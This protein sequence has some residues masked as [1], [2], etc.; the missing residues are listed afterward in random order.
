MAACRYSRFK[1]NLRIA[2]SFAVF[3]ACASAGVS[4]AASSAPP[5]ISALRKKSARVPPASSSNASASAPDL[6]TDSSVKSDIFWLLREAG[7]LHRGSRLGL[8][9]RRIGRSW[10]RIAACQIAHPAHVASL[11]RHDPH[12]RHHARPREVRDLT[13]EGCYRHLLELDRGCQELVR[14]ARRVFEVELR[15]LRCTGPE[16]LPERL[17]VIALLPTYA[18]RE[19]L[20]LASQGAPAFDR[21]IEGGLQVLDL[22]QPLQDPP[23]LLARRLRRRRPR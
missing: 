1:S 10:R 22:Q 12:R 4:S 16:Q 9:C 13:V 15:L 5:P 3:R 2:T 23:V 19:L 7:G 17:H 20:L 8:G 18:H 14:I 21:R 11:H 6:S